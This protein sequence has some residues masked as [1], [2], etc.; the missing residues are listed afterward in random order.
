VERNENSPPLGEVDE[1]KDPHAGQLS[2]ADES[3]VQM[4]TASRINR[5]TV[6][7]NNATRRKA[8]AALM[9]INTPR[10]F[11]DP[12]EVSMNIASRLSICK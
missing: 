9:S 1:R 11:S 10:A 5:I 4:E 6:L 7:C 8:N 2:F 12:D 3:D